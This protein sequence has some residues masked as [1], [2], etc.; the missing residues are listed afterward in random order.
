MW[1]ISKERTNEILLNE[2]KAKA[3]SKKKKNPQNNTPKHNNFVSKE[4]Q[5]TQE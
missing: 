4:K 2:S 1:N 5:T 3:E